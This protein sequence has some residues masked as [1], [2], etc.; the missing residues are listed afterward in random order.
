MHLFMQTALYRYTS[1]KQYSPIERNRETNQQSE[2]LTTLGA[3]E[4]EPMESDELLL[5]SL[6]PKRLW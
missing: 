5:V 1:M 3:S 6:D 2:M 4:L